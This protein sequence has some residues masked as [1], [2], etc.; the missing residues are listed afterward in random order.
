MVE[1]INKRIKSVCYVLLSIFHEY[2][3]Y[4]FVWRSDIFTIKRQ[5]ISVIIIHFNY[6][7]NYT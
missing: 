2:V 5:N 3:N 6:K 7:N 1:N 4:V